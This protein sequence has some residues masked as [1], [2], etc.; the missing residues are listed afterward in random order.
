MKRLSKKMFDFENLQ[1]AGSGGFRIVY[2]HPQDPQK[3]VK[4]CKKDNLAAVRQCLQMM[5]DEILAAQ[6]FPQLFPKVFD[7]SEDGKSL[8]VERADILIKSHQ[9]FLIANYFPE[10]RGYFA[11]SGAT[12]FMDFL[13]RI[14][15]Q[16]L[17]GKSHYNIEEIKPYNATKYFK[18]SP[19]KI[20][21]RAMTNQLFVDILTATIDLDIAYLDIDWGNVGISVVDRRFVIVDASMKSGFQ[22]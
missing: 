8:T 3:V 6:K 1:K 7:I 5:R 18:N 21:R 15:D 17:R 16:I 11:K 19:K 10:L 12:N 14:I 9:D 2:V 4:V 13:R 22:A 20:I